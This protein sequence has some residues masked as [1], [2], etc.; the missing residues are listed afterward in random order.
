M[1]ASQT[2]QQ[3]MAGEMLQFP[4]TAGTSGMT[5]TQAA[6]LMLASSSYGTAGGG[7]GLGDTPSLGSSSPALSMTNS[8]NTTQTVTINI[9]AATVVGNNGAQQL[10]QMIQTAITQT[11][12]QQAGLKL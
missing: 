6:A 2:Y 1:Q 10:A 5:A 9:N 4:N 11:L 12:R 7:P 3:S 8:N